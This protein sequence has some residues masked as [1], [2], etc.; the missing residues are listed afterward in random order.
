MN[1][2]DLQYLV[3]VADLKHF[4]KAAKACFVSQPA[5]SMQLKKLE[6]ELGVKLFER[7]N[8]KL[9]ITDVG[10][11]ITERA[12]KVLQ[13]ADEIKEAAIS[14]KDP[15]SGT[16]KLG[17]FSTLAPYFLPQI[18]PEIAS[19]LP[20]L[21]LLLVEEKTDI[22]I[23]KLKNGEIDAAF[24]ALPIDDESL[25][26]EKLFEDEFFLAV[27]AH[28]SFAKRDFIT[29]NDL[30]KKSLLL[31]EEGHCL[32]AQALDV[33]SLV[34]IS[35]HQEFRATSLET[36]R[37]MVLADVGITLI[38][39]I[40]IKNNDGLVYIPFKSKPPLRKIA[41]FWRKT[42][43]KKECIKELIKLSTHD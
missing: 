17:A 42:S 39:K 41:M 21:K 33:C 4:G 11:D 13:A 6:E 18:V 2:R 43:A 24:L 35:E 12:K 3:A 15:L 40:A 26:H 29:T 8:K 9:M 37:Q 14:Y 27:P 5:L 19:S 23:N 7:T 1:I 31:L 25:E 20:K 16:F 32:R 38:P 28:H 22:L 36:L 10:I 30:H 34:G